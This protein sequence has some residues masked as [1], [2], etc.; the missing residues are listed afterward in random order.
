M[1]KLEELARALCREAHLLQPD[2][3]LHGAGIF[4]EG[5]LDAKVDAYWPKWVPAAGAVLLALREPDAAMMAAA[6][7]VDDANDSS[8]ETRASGEWH[9][10]AMIDA[11]LGE[12]K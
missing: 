12:G 10:T 1:T 7:A 11:V 2:V 5:E 8:G 4:R 6:D 3:M 9:F